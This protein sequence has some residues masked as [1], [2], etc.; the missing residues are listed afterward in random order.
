VRSGAKSIRDP[1]TLANDAF[2]SLIGY[3]REQ[4]D[5]GAVT[6]DVI[7]SPEFRDVTQS[8]IAEALRAG[9]AVPM[10]SECVHRNGRRIPVLIA[11]AWFPG[12]DEVLCYVVD[13]TEQRLAQ[14]RLREAERR[15]STLF[16]S[17][18]EGFALAEVICDSKGN[19][20]DWRYLDVNPAFEQMSGRKREDLVGR[21]YRELFPNMASEYWVQG[22]GQVAL[23]GKPATLDRFGT[24]RGRPMRRSPTVRIPGNSPPYSATSRK[25]SKPREHCRIA[26]S[27]I[28]RCSPV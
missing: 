28:E 15:Y 16:E 26:R 3:T 7:T 1:L 14:E 24:A 2:L 25:E 17:M 4:F 11:P 13:L 6:W 9:K 8:G 18:Q 10:E 23:T 5:S 27:G 20:V 12:T 19:P 21:T 22:L